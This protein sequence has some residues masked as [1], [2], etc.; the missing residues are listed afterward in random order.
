LADATPIVNR[1]PDSSASRTDAAMDRYAAGDDDAFAEL[2][3]LLAPRLYNYLRRQTGD[4][5]RAEDLLHDTMLQIHRN[6]GRF[7]RGA[8]VTPWAFAI[9]RRFL[10]DSIRDDKRRQKIAAAVATLPE[11]APE[12]AD[13]LVESAD[14]AHRLETEIARLPDNQRTAY[15]MVRKEGRSLRE[16]ARVLGTSINAIKLRIHR[17]YTKLHAVLAGATEDGNK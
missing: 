10:I 12:R 9:A 6:R 1:R 4:G 16:V 14:V 11:K 8:R 2:Y 3:D 5:A 15:E 13:E 7:I 17:T